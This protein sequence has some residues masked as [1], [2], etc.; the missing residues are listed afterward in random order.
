VNA[1]LNYVT[2]TGIDVRNDD[3]EHVIDVIPDFTK[4]DIEDRWNQAQQLEDAMVAEILDASLC[5]CCCHRCP[6]IDMQIGL[7]DTTDPNILKILISCET[8]TIKG[9]SRI[10]LSTSKFK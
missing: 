10:R 7:K 6:H 8:K 2:A 3:P 9:P 4:P 5:A 1:H